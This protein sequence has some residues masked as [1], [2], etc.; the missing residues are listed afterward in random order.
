MSKKG[1]HR[2]KPVPPV[3]PTNSRW[4]QITALALA[5][6]CLLGWF[7]NEAA[8]TDFWWHLKTGQYI[9]Q[10]HTLP[11]PDPFGY[12]TSLIAATHPAEEPVRHFNLTHEWLAQALMYIVYLIGGFPL[13]ILARAVLLA[14][15]CALAGFLAARLS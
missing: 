6:I 15:I 13:I 12:T 4:L 9:V 3:S 1:V 14:G 7:S 8:D 11:V 5:A 2:L 10:S